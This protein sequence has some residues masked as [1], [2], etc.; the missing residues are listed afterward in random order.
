MLTKIR[1]SW[2]V[3]GQTTI[4]DKP[5]LQAFLGHAERIYLLSFLVFL[6][7][8]KIQSIRMP[9]IC[10]S[11]CRGYYAVKYSVV[12]LLNCVGYYLGE[13]ELEVT[14]NNIF[15]LENVYSS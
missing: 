9:T 12:R 5:R 11:L 2:N 1:E 10:D 4:Y 6:P 7:I 14:W 15:I 3:T 13:N 8:K